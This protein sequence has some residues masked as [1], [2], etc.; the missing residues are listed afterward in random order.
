MLLQNSVDRVGRCLDE[1]REAEG[2]VDP[3]VA[4]VQR[5]K[6]ESTAQIAAVSF[7]DAEV[8]SYHVVK[9]LIP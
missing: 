9:R 5:L 6:R 7:K 4:V 8:A 2:V 3:S 1:N